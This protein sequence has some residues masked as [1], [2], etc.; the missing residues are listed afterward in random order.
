M[1][2]ATLDEAIEGSPRAVVVAGEAGIGKTRLLSEFEAESGARARILVGNCVDLGAGAVP[3]APITAMIRTLVRQAGADAVAAAAGPGRGALAVLLPELRDT[4]HPDAADS[5][6]ERPGVAPVH[7]VIAVLLEN[8]AREHPIVAIFEDL[9][10]VDSATLA[11]LRFLLRALSDG[12]IMIVL[13]YRSDD[14]DRAHPLR[15]FLS[16]IDR[17]RLARRVDLA[18]LNR[19]QVFQ[20]AGDI[21]DQTLDPDTLE[22]VYDRSD[23]VPFFVEEL[24]GLN[25]ECGCDTD[26][27][28][29]SLRNL[30]LARYE[31]LSDPAQRLLRLLSAGG[32]S[33]SH[34]LLTAVH[35][36][37]PAELDAAA[38]EAVLAN[39]LVAEET[40]YSFRHALV[41][42]AIHTDLLPGERGRFHTAYAQALESEIQPECCS[43]EIAEHWFAAH[44]QAK[45]FPAALAAMEDARVSYAYGDAAAMGE[46]ALDLWQQ[47]PDAERIAGMSHVDLLAK[48]ASAL[49]NAGDDERSLAMVD[50]ALDE[51]EGDTSAPLNTVR[52]ARLLRDKAYYLANMALPGSIPLLEQALELVPEGVDEVLRGT[53]LNTL[54]ARLMVR[55]ELDRAIDLADQALQLARSIDSPGQAS[56]AANLAGLSRALRGEIAAG[57]AQ[58]D[59]AKELAQG[60]PAALLRYRVNASDLR[61]HLGRFDEAL[62]LAEE[63]IARARALG[64]ER[65]SG[66][67]LTSNAVD[68]LLALGQWDRAGALIDRARA[69]APPP[70]FRVYLQRAKLW[71]LLWRGEAETAARTYRGWRSSMSMQTTS[72]QTM[73]MQTTS[74]QSGTAATGTETQTLL[75]TARVLAELALAQGDLDEA[76]TQ[77]SLLF[78]DDHPVLPPYDLPLL[79]VAAAVVARKRTVSNAA[80]AEGWDP[81]A[82][83]ASVR[84]LLERERFWPTWEVWSALVDAE[85]GGDGTGN[86]VPE[87]RRALLGAQRGPAHLRPY[88]LYRLGQA[89]VATGDRAQAA[90]TLREAS[91]AAELLG[92]GLITSR[93]AAFVERAGLALTDP[94]VSRSTDGAELTA[95]EVQVLELIA[96]GL[97]NRQ[98]GEKLF[99]S[100]KTASVHVSAILRKL[101]AA[102]R[103][104][105]AFL[106]SHE[107]AH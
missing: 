107:F 102:S 52:F 12:R 71:L 4:L 86:S 60:D 8:F 35:D 61:F 1:L 39:V 10:W 74:V 37:D 6:S 38:R 53:L 27:L 100:A 62:Q 48:T 99:I 24:V 98:I 45:A 28:P 42:E 76:W 20:L 41:R 84:A 9:H 57:T 70:A 18:R 66:V 96:Q 91:A 68:P 64:V 40:R 21:F 59:S 47:L 77:A 101:G 32:V 88:A 19:P 58:L 17:A 11:V 22:R 65:S 55:S 81:S 67:I 51:A 56:I 83:E 80:A 14:V 92:A 93:V 33:V 54:A 94:A 7:E 2:R 15:T 72:M 3:Y 85:L 79:S 5:G 44:N 29:D 82:D 104:E 46:R 34:E 23:G 90:E 97:S 103:T 31:R 75:G 106:A 50:V 89:L 105:A 63:G 69:L 36:G 49:R 13:S 25:V 30:L 78:A 43:S 87:W 95:R 73:S 26:A 16:E